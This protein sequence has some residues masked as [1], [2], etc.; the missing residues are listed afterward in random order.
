M[1][2]YCLNNPINYADKSGINAVPAALPVIPLALLPFLDGPFP[3][4]EIIVIVV[5]VIG[6]AETGQAFAQKEKYKKRLITQD[7][8]SVQL[9]D[10]EKYQYT[11]YF[12]CAAGDSSQEIVYVGRVKTAN[13][14]ARMR[15]HESKGRELV[16]YVSG[17]T[18]GECR[19][20]EQLGMAYFHTI[21]RGD[22]LH[23]QIRGVSQKKMGLF[24][25]SMLDLINSGLY[26]ED[27][28]FPLSYLYNQLEN[29]ALN[30]GA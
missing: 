6:V 7:V 2:A 30:R 8:L 12:L 9:R 4:G 16:G 15:Y 28:V 21:S 19:M 27:G 18:Y 10:D 5:V 20:L 11:V 1:F 22:S 24:F 14:K 25:G 23:N 3:V 17:L 29:E 13:I 26:P